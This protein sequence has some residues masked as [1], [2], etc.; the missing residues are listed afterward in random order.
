MF[1]P[2]QTKAHKPTAK[3]PS[4]NPNNP[5]NPHNPK[6]PKELKK[7]PSLSTISRLITTT[8]R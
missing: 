6:K 5:H 8:N 1:K 7:S 2:V 4:K 3:N